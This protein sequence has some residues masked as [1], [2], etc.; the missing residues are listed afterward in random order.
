VRLPLTA[1][2]RS[3]DPVQAD[4]LFAAEEVALAYESLLQYHYLKRPYALGPNLAES[5][6]QESPDG[7]TYTFHLKKGVLFQDDPCFAAS[8]GRGRELVAEDVVYSLKRLADPRL[9]ASGWW[10]LDGKI[11]GLD[12]WREAAEKSGK[13]DYSKALPGLQVTDRYTLKIVLKKRS[14]QFLYALAMPLTG[15]VPREAVDY[16]GAD[17]SG[18]P[19]GSGPFRL[20]EY[21]PSA[22]ITWVRNPTYR[23]EMYP[24]DGAPGDAE[25]GLLADAGKPLPLADRIEMVL[26]EQSGPL[27]QDFLAGKLDLIPLPK[28]VYDQ[29]ITHS[30][31]L[32]SD[33]VAKGLRLLKAQRMDV[34]HLS[35]N[36]AD[37]LFSAA[38]GKGKA[39]RQAISMAYDQAGAID[40]FYN[41]RA[42]PAE[43]PIPPGLAG[44]DPALKNPYRKL[45][46]ARA[47]ELLE[48]AGL[49]EEL[50]SLE[51]ASDT[52]TTDKILV[53]F[54]ERSLGS[55]GFKAT[56]SVLSWSDFRE[57]LRSRKGQLWSSAWA[58][59]YP[60]AQ[61]VLQLFYGRNVSPGPNDSNYSNPEYDRLY[62]RAIDLPDSL[63]RTT[64]YRQLAGIIVED[65]PWIPTV[66][67]IQY[68]L[69]QKRLRNYKFHDFDRGFGK[70]LG[71]DDRKVR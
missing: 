49:P 51:Y 57:L 69:A 17:F 46:V 48:K 23:K 24:A 53:E 34:V 37:P 38:G 63:E 33:F 18:H 20:S 64:L 68:T 45:N 54:I 52:A 8:Q 1:V 10:L 32:S 47:R 60:D 42:I 65:C 30:K 29:V 56:S 67:R 2:I 22:R 66:H 61:S 31:E 26:Y 5:M 11:R 50:P 7:T 4:D 3:L 19:V 62:E 58:L 40:L 39:L 12:E 6:P 13:A 41:G 21:L 25:A 28:D 36:L 59:D 27:W 43:G 71:A 15:I 55:L 35:F 16:Y 70:Y 14:A 44:Y 9:A